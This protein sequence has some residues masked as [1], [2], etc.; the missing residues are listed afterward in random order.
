[1][2]LLTVLAASVPFAAAAGARRTASSLDRMREELRPRHLDV[3]FHEGEPPA[4]ALQRLAGLPGVEIVGE[5]ASILARPQGSDREQ[6]EAF[7]QG[8]L[9]QVLGRASIVRV[10]TPV[11]WLAPLTKS[12]FRLGLLAISISTSAGT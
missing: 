5:A 11:D 9:D 4:D 2:V 1:L 7:G 6:F 3:Q 10:S 12:W 8:G